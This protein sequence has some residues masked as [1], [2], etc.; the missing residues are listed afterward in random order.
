MRRSGNLLFEI[1][2]FSWIRTVLIKSIIHSPT[3]YLLDGD[4]IAANCDYRNLVA[5]GR[6][7]LGGDEA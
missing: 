1:V 6:G 2:L 3:V 7:D 4:L 5:L